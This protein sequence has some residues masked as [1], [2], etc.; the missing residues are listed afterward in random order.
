MADVL[1]PPEMCK[2]FVYFLLIYVYMNKL[3]PGVH[4]PGVWIGD[5]AHLRH[6]ERT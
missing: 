5:V 1:S 2:R 3:W 4:S 6:E